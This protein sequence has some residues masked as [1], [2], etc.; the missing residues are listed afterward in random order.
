MWESARGMNLTETT[1]RGQ[2]VDE[3]EAVEVNGI[4]MVVSEGG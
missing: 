4:F 3:D 1:G 2:G